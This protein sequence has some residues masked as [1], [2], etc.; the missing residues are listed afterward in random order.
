[1]S[2]DLKVFLKQLMAIG[3]QTDVWLVSGGVQEGIAQYLGAKFTH[4]RVSCQA[5][6]TRIR[7][8]C[9]RLYANVNI[10]QSTM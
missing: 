2:T 8:S 9:Q 6:F 1:M 4:V 10:T 7:V 3:R 5:K